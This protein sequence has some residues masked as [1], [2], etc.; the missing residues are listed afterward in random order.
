MPL[1][2]RKFYTGA[3]YRDLTHEKAKCICMKNPD[4]VLTRR[5]WD[6][7]HFI[8]DGNYYIFLKSGDILDCGGFAFDLSEKVYDMDKTD[9]IVASRTEFAKKLEGFAHII[10]WEKY[11]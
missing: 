2:K 9:W 7:Y 11:K 3:M 1:K 4:F 8:K 10:P 5:E 6:G